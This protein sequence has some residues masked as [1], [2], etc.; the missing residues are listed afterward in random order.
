MQRMED[1]RGAD[2][3]V[4]PLLASESYDLLLAVCRADDSCLAVDYKQMRDLLERIC[5]SQM[6]HESLQMTDLSARISF[7]S[8]K[9]DLS[10]GEQNRLHTFRLTSNQILNHTSQPVREHLLRDAKTL[11]FF[12]RKLSG[13]DIPEAL[14]RLLP[15]ADATYLAAPLP[16]KRVERMRV[17]FQESDAQYLYVTPLDEVSETLLKVRYGVP[18]INEEF[19]ETCRVLWKHAQLNLLDVAVDEA[20]ILTPSF[21]VL[22]PDYLLDISALA[23]CFRDYGHHP[24]NYLLRVFSPSKMHVRCFWE[25]LPISFWMNGFIPKAGK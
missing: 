8:S 7:V 12:V 21:I 1:K 14:Y 11:A 13:E 6:Q 2:R 10:V 17:C 25:T 24:A 9:L 20:G 16:H 4:D 22:E 18:Q 23:E 15:A 3:T 5:R 19:N